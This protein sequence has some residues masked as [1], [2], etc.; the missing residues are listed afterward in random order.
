MALQNQTFQLNIQTDLKFGIDIVR[1]EL[2]NSIKAARKKKAF[3]VTDKGL[4]DAGVIA[5][6]T[7]PLEEAGLS[8]YVFSDVLPNP[9]ANSVMAGVETYK[10]EEA[11]LIVTIGGGSA[12]DY[13]KALAVGATHEG[14]VLDYSIGRKPVQ[15]IVPLLFAIPTT[16][17]TGSEVTRVSVI[18]DTDAGRKL[19]LA[20]SYLVPK[21]VFV[22]PTLTLGLPRAHV[23]ATGADALVHAIEAYVS[24]PA[25]PF[26]DGLA[27]QAIRMIWNNLPQT[28]AHAANLEARAQV[29][30]ASTLAGMAFNLSGLG[31]VHSLSHP[32]SAR[33]HVPHGL[34]NAILLPYIIEHNLPANPR[35]YA[36]IARLLDPALYQETDKD[37]AA[38]LIS[39]VQ[40]FLRLIDIPETFAY[41]GIEFTAVQVEELS[42]DAMNDHGTVHFNPRKAVKEDIARI[43]KRALP[44]V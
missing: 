28:Y 24:L 14:F 6:V 15:D 30:L 36:D 43:Y 18:T 38:A 42:E 29:H 41:T 27:L 21:V 10:R 34:A 17:G 1:E 25:N 31:M 26:T 40:Q 9:P 19:V 11:D 2:A 33:Y 12:I 4:V 23:A 35:K 5:K 37:A 8:Y 20:S 13:A 44:S 32:M 16:I 7:A 22:D 3:I 39:L